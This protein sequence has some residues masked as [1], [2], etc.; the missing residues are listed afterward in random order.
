MLAKVPS[1]H[2]AQVVKI[3]SKKIG[4]LPAELRRSL[5]WDRGTEMA[6]HKDLPIATD[7]QVYLCDPHSP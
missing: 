6:N 7:A 1:R 2:S 3:L 5:T 4:S